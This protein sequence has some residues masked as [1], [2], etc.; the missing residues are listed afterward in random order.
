MLIWVQARDQALDRMVRAL[1]PGGWLVI[2]HFD[3][4]SVPFD[5]AFDRPEIVV[6]L[7]Q[8][9]AAAI[10]ARSGDCQ[11]GRRL[12]RLFRSSGLEEVGS[13]ER[14]LDWQRGLPWG[15]GPR[16]RDD[17]CRKWAS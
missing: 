11:I 2:E 9:M 17:A 12:P 4:L 10:R 16:H 14:V 7:Y 6:R 13:E 5:P 15:A 8:G 1:K 3:G